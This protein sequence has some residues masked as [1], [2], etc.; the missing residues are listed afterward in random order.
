MGHLSMT[1][2]YIRPS[3]LTEMYKKLW[4]RLSLKKGS[5]YGEG[6]D[7]WVVLD[8]VSFFIQKKKEGSLSF[9]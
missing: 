5:I 8:L 4:N 3:S 9:V 2:I 1:K 7:E 6:M